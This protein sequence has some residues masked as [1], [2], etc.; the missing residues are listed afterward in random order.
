M[1]NHDRHPITISSADIAEALQATADHLEAN[2]AAVDALALAGLDDYNRKRH[3][4]GLDGDLTPEQQFRAIARYAYLM[5]YGLALEDMAEEINGVN[6]DD[7]FYLRVD[8]DEMEP[9]I[10]D[11]DLIGIARAECTAD[12]QRAKA[13]AIWKDGRT[14]IGRLIMHSDGTTMIIQAHGDGTGHLEPFDPAADFIGP[15]VSIRRSL[16]RAD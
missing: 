9:D 10:L 2:P 7:V 15:V 4:M 1:Q 3:E 16:A 12:L 8:G 11:G 14:L 13:V 5:G 6:G